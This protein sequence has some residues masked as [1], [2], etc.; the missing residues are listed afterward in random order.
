MKRIASMTVVLALTCQTALAGP[1]AVVKK[2]AQPIGEVEYGK[3]QDYLF[4]VANV[5]DKPL[6]LTL[7]KRP[8]SCLEVFAPDQIEPGKVETVKLRWAPPPGKHGLIALATEFA[9]NDP[10]SKAISLRIEGKVDP[11]IHIAPAKSSWV[12]FGD[13]VGNAPPQV[14][15]V[16]STK[17]PA[18]R[19]EAS[20]ID[21]K[22][23]KP[24]F[25]VSVA[26]LKEGARVDSQTVKSGYAVK[27]EAL[28][29]L[30]PGYL[31]RELVLKIDVPNEAQ[32]ETIMPIY[33]VVPSGV[34]TVGPKEI[35]FNNQRIADGDKARARVRFNVPDGKEFVKIVRCEPAFVK[36]DTPRQVAKG[37][38][39]FTLTVPKNNPDAIKFQPDGFFEGKVWLQTSGSDAEVPV[40]V[41]W[42]GP[43]R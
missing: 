13:I 32:R 35:A 27:V 43:E 34:F 39:E 33:G 9:T 4:D 37:V 29:D 1:H 36:A 20:V 2:P 25:K 31:R 38:W 42:L 26:A 5:G 16:Y 41:K 11:K 17:L 23:D 22:D 7:S 18:F 12:E 6:T 14:L 8:C 30:P 40:R 15:H 28:K 3:P 10:T 24:A 21:G 19:V